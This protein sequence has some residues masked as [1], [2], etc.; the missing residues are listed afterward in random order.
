MQY[1]Y[2]NNTEDDEIIIPKSRFTEREILE[3]I[4]KKYEINIDEIIS[5]MNNEKKEREESCK[6]HEYMK[7]IMDNG[8]IVCIVCD[9]INNCD[10]CSREIL[11]TYSRDERLFVE[12]ICTKCK[13]KYNYYFCSECKSNN[14]FCGC[15]KG[16]MCDGK[17]Y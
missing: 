1:C 13:E 2:H 12:K 10:V 14:C 11:F 17:Y 4:I 15:P 7:H 16:C 5:E 6:S 8:K 9:K 3:K